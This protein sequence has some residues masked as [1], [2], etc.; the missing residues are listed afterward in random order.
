VLDNLFEK[1]YDAEWARKEAIQGD[2]TL[3]LGVLALL[4]SG[5]VVLLKEYD[6]RGGL[7]DVV[8]WL[9]FGIGSLAYV[10]AVYLIVRSF[11]GFIYLH[12]SFPSALKKY[13]D[14]LRAH[15]SAKGTPLLAD[16]EFEEYLQGLLIRA[17]DRNAA[18]NVSRAEYLRKTNRAII[19]VLIASGVSAIPY[20]VRERAQNHGAASVE[21]IHGGS[22]MSQSPNAATQPRPPIPPKPVP[23]EPFEERTGVRPPGGW[24]TSRNGRGVAAALRALFAWRS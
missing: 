4:G 11:Y 13:W 12:L 15:H 18:I 23:P 7:L 8:F 1:L 17:T 10:A 14:D 16:R 20:S 22:A 5:L 6:L 21:T 24:H 19:V 3:P 9:G 2:T